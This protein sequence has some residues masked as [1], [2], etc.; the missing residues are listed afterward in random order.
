[1]IKA[2][3]TTTTSQAAPTDPRQAII[4]LVSVA[5]AEMHPAARAAKPEWFEHL[6]RKAERKAE[7]IA[8]RAALSPYACGDATFAEVF[9][10]TLPTLFTEALERLDSPEA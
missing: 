4:A 3:R 5:V 8:T 1:M 9:A 2:A 6:L 10:K 7:K